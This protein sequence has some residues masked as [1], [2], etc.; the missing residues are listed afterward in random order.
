MSNSRQSWIIVNDQIHRRDELLI[1]VDAR[2]VR[3]GDGCFET[4]RSYQGRF[5]KLEAHLERLKG[6]LE[7]LRII[8]SIELEDK[9]F[10]EKILELLTENQLR[11]EDA[12]VRIQVWREGGRGF[13]ISREAD[14]GYCIT[15]SKLPQ[16]SRAVSLATVATRRIPAEA[17]NPRF[18]L[19]NSINY[20]QAATQASEQQADDALMLTVDGLVAETTI[21]N[22]FWVNDQTVCTPSIDCDILPGITR[23]MILEILATKFD[24]SVREGQ[25][26]TADL[27]HADA[28]WICNSVREL[29]P[30]R[31]ID[32]QTFS[33]ENS[34]FLKLKEAFKSYKNKLLA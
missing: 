3:Y 26:T 17:L 9:S 21:A 28:A 19:S 18:K 30:V 15:V 5:L 13:S 16:I 12:V 22:I 34:F 32:D 8:P 10:R 25:F 1:P 29:V 20:I 27:K 14:S 2:A 7:Y 31:K 6:A 4:F 23:N 11:D 33:L 24:V